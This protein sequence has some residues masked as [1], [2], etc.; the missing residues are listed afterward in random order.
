MSGTRNPIL[1]SSP[2]P[3]H[4]MPGRS[5]GSLGRNDAGDPDARM[6]MAA[7]TPGSVGSGGDRAMSLIPKVKMSCEMP[8]QVIEVDL[9]KMRHFLYTVAYAEATNEATTRGFASDEIH[10][11]N[12]LQVEA[13]ARNGADKLMN[14]LQEALANGPE[15]VKAFVAKQEDRKTRARA[16]LNTK[17]TEALSAGSWWVSV[18]G[19]T[20]KFLSAVKFASTVTIKTL[21]IFSGAAGTAVDWAYSATQE[22][23]KNLQTDKTQ[24]P[25]AVVVVDET[26]KNIGQ[27]ILTE[28]NEA[29]ANGLMTREEKNKIEGLIGN[30]KGNAKQIEERLAKLEKQIEES[31]KTAKGAKKIPGLKSRNLEALAK[32]KILRINTLKAFLR[33]GRPV[34]L[35]K[36]V[37]G[38]V[39][40]LAFLASDVKDAWNEAAA[41]WRASD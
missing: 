2:L 24:K 26:S 23:V 19:G 16:A 15:A 21:S 13:T 18:F 20:V 25:L 11:G 9:A 38:K 14:E 3:G 22:G 5:P 12:E 40:S 39:F 33:N 28:L 7:D 4:V 8:I 10:T 17:F 1:G 30:Y 41:E 36:K 37:S 27:E 32:L 31:L 34:G 35:A 6:C 29:V